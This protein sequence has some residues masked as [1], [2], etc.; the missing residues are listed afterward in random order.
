M[1]KRS[2]PVQFSPVRRRREKKFGRDGIDVQVDNAECILSRRQAAIVR[3]W[4]CKSQWV[5]ECWNTWQGFFILVH[6]VY[7]KSPY[8][9]SLIHSFIHKETKKVVDNRRRTI[10]SVSTQITDLWLHFLPLFFLFHTKYNCNTNILWN[11]WPTFSKNSLSPLAI[12]R[13]VYIFLFCCCFIRH[14]SFLPTL[15]KNTNNKKKVVVICMAWPNRII[16]VFGRV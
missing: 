6:N 15:I 10:S 12:G 1:A 14:Q 16:M 2:C 13:I 9:H 5:S 8:I 7:N 3:W 4:W 11:L